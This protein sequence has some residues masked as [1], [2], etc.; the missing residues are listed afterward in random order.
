VS[1]HY[2]GGLSSI[3]AALAWIDAAVHPL[4]TEDAPLREAIGRALTREIRAERPIPACHSAAFDGFAV[5]ADQTVGASSYNLLSLPLIELSAGEA[6]PAGTDAIV[7]IE[8][9]EPDGAGNV[10]VVEAWAAGSNVDRL[11]T[12]VDAGEILMSVGTVV[13]RRHI[14]IL[15]AAGFARLPA[16]RRPR[17][18]IVLVG[19]PRAGAPD[20]N[21]PM[22]S[23]L[24]ERDGGTVL[25]RGTIDRCRSV[26]ADTIRASR[27]D[28]V[29]VGGGT[30]PGGEDQSAPALAAAGELAIHGIAFR[31]GET[32]GLGRTATGVPVIL[33][34]GSPAACLCCYELLAGRAIRRLGGRDPSLPYRS[35]MMT[36]ARKI[37]SAT[38]MTE[39]VPVSCRPGGSIE[40]VA[41]FSEIGLMAAASADG[42]VIVPETSEGYPPGAS[43]NVY[44]YDDR[45]GQ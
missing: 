41:P 13:S 32:A 1:G 7:P 5:A 35:C 2:R 8:H 21:G 6:L 40:P 9:G 4:E 14:G 31:P 33:L 42:F 38:G 45:F 39:I 28:I 12:V 10:A 20:S 16:I 24:I 36:T 25:E 29:L 17:V 30:G 15:A 27:A 11:G 44:L 23:T 26:L 3:E 19:V 43:V 18:E 34:P 22:L 37:V